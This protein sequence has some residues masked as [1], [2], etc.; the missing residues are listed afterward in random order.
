MLATSSESEQ[1]WKLNN[2]VIRIKDK[3]ILFFIILL[4]E[5]L[6]WLFKAIKMLKYLLNNN[7]CAKAFV[8]EK[9]QTY[10]LIIN[11]SDISFLNKEGFFML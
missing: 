3:K 6:Y 8:N 9:S 7:S 4:Y 5:R 10:I 2:I 1:P 11:L